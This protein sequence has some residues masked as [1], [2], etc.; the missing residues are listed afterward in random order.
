MT[1][2]NEQTVIDLYENVQTITHE[3]LLAAQMKNWEEFYSL[4]RRCDE[5]VSTLK[6][7][8]AVAK[9]SGQLLERKFELIQS[10]LGTDRA[11]RKITE[12]WMA[13]L[14]SMLKNNTSSRKLEFAYNSG[15]Y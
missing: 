5:E 3:M 10:I 6:S 12:P 15:A 9:L 4:G 2:M 11:I 1:I 7:Y 13:Q 14:E 8:D